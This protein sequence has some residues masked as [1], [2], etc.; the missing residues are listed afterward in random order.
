MGH[1]AQ[2]GIAENDVGRNIA[3]VCQ[4]SPELAQL[5]EQR[6]IAFDFAGL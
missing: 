1:V 3:L 4:R 5:L 2:G 6:L